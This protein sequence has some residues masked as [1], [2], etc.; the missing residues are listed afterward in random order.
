MWPWIKK[1][2]ISKEKEEQVDF[3]QIVNFPVAFKPGHDHT[4]L[5]DNVYKGAEFQLHAWLH[6]QLQ[7]IV[8]D[9]QQK[10]LES[11]N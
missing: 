8:Q 7:E 5:S 4:S 10:I 1:I 3:R 2:D 6:Y 9:P 11:I